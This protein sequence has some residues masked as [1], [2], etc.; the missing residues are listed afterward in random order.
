MTRIT[1]SRNPIVAYT[2]PK[3]KDVS[4]AA[5]DK[6]AERLLAAL[7]KESADIKAESDWKLFRDRWMARK[8]GVLTQ[9]NELWLNSAPK[10][11]KRE[12]GQ[13]VNEI[14]AVVTARVEA[15]RPKKA[16]ILGTG[17]G[18]QA[19]QRGYGIATVISPISPLDITHHG[20]P[21]P[22]GPDHSVLKQENEIGSG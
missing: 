14:K 16:A 22:C 5:L 17:A 7:K 15:L 13:R 8:N 12:V 18:Q 1:K 10:D 21:R 9:I 6:A 3:L 19:K 2:V 11:A 20:N 4:P